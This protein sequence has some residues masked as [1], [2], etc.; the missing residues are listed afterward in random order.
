MAPKTVAAILV[1]AMITTIVTLD[2]LFL[3]DKFALRLVT[4]VVIAAVFLGLALFTLRK[5]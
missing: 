4:N 5:K 1:V 2:V 3:R